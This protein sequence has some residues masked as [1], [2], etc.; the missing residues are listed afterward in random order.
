MYGELRIGARGVGGG[1]E[2]RVGRRRGTLVGVCVVNSVRW[3]WKV[4][5]NSGIGFR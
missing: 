2:D 1:M 3:G 5:H 4:V